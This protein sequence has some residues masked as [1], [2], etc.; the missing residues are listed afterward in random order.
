MKRVFLLVSIVAIL[1]FVCVGFAGAVNN[2][3][4]LQ[5]NVKQGGINLANGNLTVYIYDA[6]S[7]G[8]LIYNS[9]NEFN[10]AV[11]DGKY[12]VLL[13]NNSANELT[14]N[15]GQLYYLEIYVNWENFSFNG[16]QRQMFQSSVGN[17]SSVKINWTNSILLPEG[18]NITLG[19]GGWVKGMF[20][21]V[22]DAVSANYM[23]FNSTTLWFNETYLNRTIDL[24]AR[25]SAYGNFTELN[26]TE[27]FRVGSTFYADVS[28]VNITG[29]TNFNSGWQLGGVS[30]IGGEVFAQ[31][32]YVY[33]ITS[34][35]VTHMNVN[36]SLIPQFD[37]EFDIGN[38]S[39]RYKNGYFGT[40]VFINGAPVSGLFNNESYL[41]TY[42]ASY[43]SYGS[44][45]ST[46]NIQQ[47]LNLT[48]IYST[49]NATYASGVYN[50]SL[51]TSNMWNETWSSTY[52]ISYILGTN[53]TILGLVNNESYLSTYNASYA[54]KTSS[55]W[56][57][58][59]STLYNLT[60]MVGI[61]IAPT[62]TFEVFGSGMNVSN[63]SSG[64]ISSG[65]TYFID[66]WRKNFNI[67]ASSGDYYG[68]RFYNHLVGTNYAGSATTDLTGMIVDI[69]SGNNAPQSSQ[70]G[71]LIG[72]WFRALAYSGNM[73]YSQVIGVYA[74]PSVSYTGGG[75]ID[76]KNMTFFKGELQNSGGGSTVNILQGMEINLKEPNDPINTKNRYGIYI[77]GVKGARI[78]NYAIFA[79]SG[80]VAI[81]NTFYIINSTNNW[82]TG[83]GIGTIQPSQRLEVNGSI[84]MSGSY[85]NFSVGGGRIYWDDTNSRMV[86]EVS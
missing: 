49:Y 81:N 31:S 52:N 21:W 48:D 6:P 85:S 14:L 80:N 16:A 54:G 35:Y 22:I 83:V 13:G 28:E 3:V 70:M 43:A 32:L 73:N 58:D 72:L 76:V 74:Q 8:T 30:I 12:D 78:D 38:V 75:T 25:T 53:S 62:K 61:G 9:S 77:S 55:Q 34:L 24:R 37:N 41:S 15:Y 46:S 60:A 39:Q 23:T 18:Q 10:D 44:F 33:N 69:R 56:V 59:I 2:L 63:T 51:A 71:N 47:L 17:I 5:G 29:N 19:A 45:N 27:I 82:G 79:N 57:A 20:N 11:S 7:G 36:G 67:G 4:S 66:V 86:I 65:D 50:Y 26:V 64:V 68:A 42:N 84:N 40:D 1:I